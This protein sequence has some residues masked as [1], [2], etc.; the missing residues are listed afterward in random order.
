MINLSGLSKQWHSN[1]K[2]V[3]LMQRQGYSGGTVTDSNRIPC[4]EH[5]QIQFFIEHI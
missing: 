2:R 4:A 5:P 1:A 3:P